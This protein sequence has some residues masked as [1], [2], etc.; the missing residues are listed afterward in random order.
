MKAADLI[1][2]LRAIA[3]EAA[4]LIAGV[5]ATPFEVEYK[6][7]SDPVTIADRRAND[8][9][10]RRLQQQFPGVPVVAEE[11][12]PDTFAGFQQEPFVFF[13]D[14]LD[15]T[16]EFVQ[17]NGEFVVMIGLIDESGPIAGVLHAPATG[18]EYWGGR[19]VPATHRDARGT[20][21]ALSV[22]AAA[23]LA[24][25]TVVSSR[26]HRS[27]RVEAA[28]AALGA[29]RIDALGS[30]GLKCA[31]VAHGSADA[32]V[33]PGYAGSR[34]DVC[35]GEAIVRAAG[36]LVTDTEGAPIDYRGAGLT[37]D[38]G[39]VASNGRLHGEIVERLAALAD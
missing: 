35:A 22:S 28:L 16:R 37:N 32:Y 3:T 10:C 15:G 21:R 29:A 8:L 38:R 33:A 19:E 23:R 5:Y 18:E 4:E 13:V 12:A 6:K 27:V 11:S 24:D 25:A 14:P 34:W 31:A 30:A 2:S 1:P 9:I 36:G 26:S 20:T 7:P 39:I 17:K